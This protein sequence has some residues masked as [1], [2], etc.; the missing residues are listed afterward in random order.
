MSLKRRPTH[1]CRRV[2]VVFETITV[3]TNLWDLKQKVIYS[4]QWLVVNSLG[5]QLP[6]TM[7]ETIR[8]KTGQPWRTAA[9]VHPVDNQFGM[10]CENSEYSD[11]VYNIKAN[12]AVRT[13]K[14]K[15]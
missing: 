11:Y 4:I 1:V 15:I 2:I 3:M 13:H 14:S 7:L 5:H 9:G 12:T 6:R 10:V 8:R